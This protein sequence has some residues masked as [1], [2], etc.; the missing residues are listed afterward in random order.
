[1]FL[2]ISQNSQWKTCSRVSFL[3]KLQASTCNSIKRGSET[4]VFL[5]IFAK[6]LR[7]PFLQNTSW[8]MLFY[9]GS[10]KIPVGYWR[11][12]FV[13]S[14]KRLSQLLL[15]KLFNT[16]YF[17]EYFQKIATVLNPTSSS[18]Y[19]NITKLWDAKR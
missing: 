5:R 17:E 3:I 2:E 4:G 8:R 7:K 6:F 9:M 11:L 15:L 14:P 10:H 19:K 16:T 12:G 18:R 13:M 1:M